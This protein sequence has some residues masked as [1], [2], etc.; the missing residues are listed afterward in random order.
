MLDFFIISEY[1]IDG[2]WSS[3]SV[4]SLNCEDGGCSRVCIKSLW[5][6]KI[7]KTSYFLEILGNILMLISGMRTYTDVPSW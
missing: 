4:I 3:R 1:E 2:A 5:F 6:S 7:W